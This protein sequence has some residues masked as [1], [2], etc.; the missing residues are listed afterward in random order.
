[1][2][3]TVGIR[4]LV[5]VEI[6]RRALPV[7]SHRRQTLWPIIREFRSDSHA[8]QHGYSAKAATAANSVAVD[9]AQVLFALALD[10]QPAFFPAT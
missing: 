3:R 7:K 10:A 9:N 1:M 4:R 8:T 5:P 6:S 2:S